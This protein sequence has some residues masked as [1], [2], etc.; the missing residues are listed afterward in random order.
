[1]FKLLHQEPRWKSFV[2]ISNEPIFTVEQCNS[3]IKIGKECPKIKGSVFETKNNK[4][5]NYENQNIEKS[6]INEDIRKS[7]IS[8]IPF[9]KL[10]PMY[11]QLTQV[12]HQMNNNFFGFEGIQL[13]EPAQYTEYSLGDFYDWHIDL[14]TTGETQAPVRKISMS[15]LLSD[16]NEFEGGDLDIID[17]HK[18][19]V[20]QQGQAIFFASFLRHRVNPVT[21]GNRKSLV[22][23]FGGPPFK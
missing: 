18:K 23:W 6:N 11:N 12:I 2:V 3:I 8:W 10:T 9:E 22:V 13:N 4:Q 16:P 21:K 1:M 17:P 15:L 7:N 20:L 14:N 5:N 19:A